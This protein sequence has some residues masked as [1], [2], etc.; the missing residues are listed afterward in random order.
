MSDDRGASIAG[1]DDFSMGVV[2]WVMPRFLDE[3]RII[4]LRLWRM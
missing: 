2:V 3:A 4:Y 1:R